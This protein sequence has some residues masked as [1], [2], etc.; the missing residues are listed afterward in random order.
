MTKPTDDTRQGTYR[1]EQWRCI[2]CGKNSVTYQHRQA[3]GM[4]GSRKVP[5]CVDG[6][7]A[8][9]W[10]NEGFEAAGQTEALVYGWKV[11]R[12]V[13]DAGAVPVFNKPL[14]LWAQLMPDGGVRILQPRDAH[15]AMR[16]AY[17]SEWDRWVDELQERAGFWPLLGMDG[18][19][20]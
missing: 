16:R 8:C 10:C 9:L 1:R 19:T 12:W 6:V 7:A 13:T 5:T 11:R 20:R 2:R 14:R 4:G 15:E 17:G 3:D 18:R